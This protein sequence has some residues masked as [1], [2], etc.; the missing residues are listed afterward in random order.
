MIEITLKKHLLAEPH[1][2]ILYDSIENLPIHQF[3][4]MQK[5]HMIQGGVGKNLSEFDNHFESVIEFLKHDKKDKAIGEL[6]N[7]RLL[8]WHILNEEDPSHLAFCCM[9]QS[10]DNK[11]IVDYSE[12]S[13]ED[14]RKRLSG[15]GLTQ[16]IMSEQG[17]KKKF[18][19][20]LREYFPEL[21][22]KGP[23]LE[24][25]GR[26]KKKLLLVCDEILEGADNSR[27]IETIESYILGMIEVPDFNGF[28]DDKQ[29]DKDFE[30]MCAYMQ[31]ETTQNVKNITVIEFHSLMLN[32]YKRRPKGK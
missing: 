27:Q 12:K 28:G 20:Q 25:L 11:P 22:E 2:V 8:F 17:G 6:K 31:K 15:Y 29:H 1:I 21:S 7:M 32:I 30:S 9:V 23:Y 18:Q 26:K 19:E 16:K 5:Y 4:K 13:L 3:S 24:I 14:I 10:I